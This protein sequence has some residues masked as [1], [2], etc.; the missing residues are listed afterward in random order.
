MDTINY[1]CK[2]CG[3]GIFKLKK[4]N[5]KNIY[6]CVKCYFSLEIKTPSIQKKA[7]EEKVF[8]NGNDVEAS[9]DAIKNIECCICKNNLNKNLTYS[10]KNEIIY[11]YCKACYYSLNLPKQ[12]RLSYT[13]YTN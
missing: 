8:D 2:Y 9:N 4:S 6:E 13:N 11:Y 3:N 7:E 10:V 12:R 5:K 1:P